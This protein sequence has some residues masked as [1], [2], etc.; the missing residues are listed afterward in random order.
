MAFLRGTRPEL[1]RTSVAMRGGQTVLLLLLLAT[2]GCSQ[3]GKELAQFAGEWDLVWTKAVFEEVTVSTSSGNK[4][5]MN[6]PRRVAFHGKVSTPP[7]PP[8]ISGGQLPV[9]LDLR[10]DTSAKKYL[11]NFRYGFN[12]YERIEDLALESDAGRNFRGTGTLLES[13]MPPAVVEVEI[14]ATDN[15]SD[16]KIL[17]PSN[18]KTPDGKGV[19][20]WRSYT[21]EFRKPKT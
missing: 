19:Q 7:V 2:G 8:Y 10:Y 15:G 20:P 14:R 13:G 16:W 4:F 6:G 21:F 5:E 3:Q 17:A 9:D 11:F 18:V 12:D 1:Q